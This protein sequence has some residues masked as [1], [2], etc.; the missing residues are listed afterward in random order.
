MMVSFDPAIRH[1]EPTMMVLLDGLVVPFSISTEIPGDINRHKPKIV[2][3]NEAAI[4]I[5]DS[6]VW[7]KADDI[8]RLQVTRPHDAK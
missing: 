1:A 2:I 8:D 4:P 3:V 5:R 7:I 6:R